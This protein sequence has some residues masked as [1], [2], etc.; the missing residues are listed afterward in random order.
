MRSERTHEEFCDL[1]SRQ[2]LQH[3]REETVHDAP[4][5]CSAPPREPAVYDG[6][7]YS[8]MRVRSA[9][10]IKN[11]FDGCHGLDDEPSVKLALKA[12]AD[13]AERKICAAFQR[14]NCECERRAVAL[15]APRD[16]ISR[17]PV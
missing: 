16:P 14:E 1:L 9:R 7:S 2:R 11:W 8:Y 17:P 5:K 12:G 3:P 15:V 6:T 4:M 13:G 10:V